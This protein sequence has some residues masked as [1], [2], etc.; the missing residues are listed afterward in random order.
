MSTIKLPKN[1][2]EFFKNN[3]DEIFKTGKLAE[4]PWNEE[5]SKKIKIITN[6]KNA[7]GVN[8]NGSGIVALLLIYKEYYGRTDVM[9]QSNTM[10][11][12]KT[13]TKTAGYNLTNVIDCRLETLMPSFEDLKK[14]VNNYNKE[15]EK[16]VII[17]S[18]IGGIINPDIEK[19]VKFCKEKNI[20]LI[21][22]SAHSFGS[23]LNKKFS[24]TFGN[25]GVYSY[26]S[27]KA[28]FAGEG[29][30]VV[31]NDN[32]IGDLMR[33]FI[34]Y[35]RFKRKMNIGCNIRLAELQAL[36]IY[37]VIKEYEEIIKNKFEIAKKYLEI[38]KSLDI[39]YISQKNDLISGNYY[40]FTII[41]PRKNISEL[42]PKV[43]TTT[44]KVYEY[45]LGASKEIPLKHLCL[46]IWF[47]LKESV[48]DK[49]VSEL[50]NSLSLTI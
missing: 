9:V 29:G 15:T 48:S 1:S 28:I 49:V 36:M 20:I 43:K 5:L 13:M 6:V 40:K 14:A 22:D 34:A 8:S 18:D 10:Y 47:N 35:D 37:S 4:G 33:D 44:S 7:I 12:V 23:T 25:A 50:K 30:V 38:C 3:Q 42:L 39:K 41:S 24:G 21:E 31:T 17:L 45:A 19:I 32:N 2:I 46:P 27:T 26:Y 11:G 16:L